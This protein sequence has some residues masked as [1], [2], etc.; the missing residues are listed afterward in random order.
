MTVYEIFTEESFQIL[1]DMDPNGSMREFNVFLESTGSIN[2]E[3]RLKLKYLSGIIE[4]N[5]LMIL[6][7]IHQIICYIVIYGDNDEIV[8][9]LK[10]LILFHKINEWLYKIK[11]QFQDINSIYRPCL[12]NQKTYDQCEL[13]HFYD[14]VK[15]EIPHYRDSILSDL[16]HAKSLILQLPKPSENIEYLDLFANTPESC[17]LCRNN[18][19]EDLV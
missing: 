6:E 14:A 9:H 2:F 16:N 15:F 3:F 18:K 10:D 13:R 1:L 19:N 17:L 11:D 4:K 8:T 12:N 5:K 7:I